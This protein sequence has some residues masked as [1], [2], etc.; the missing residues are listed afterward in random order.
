VDLGTNQLI[1]VVPVT[2]GFPLAVALSSDETKVIVGTDLGYEVLNLT[3]HAS[4]ATVSVGS[5]NAFSRHPSDP[6]LYATVNGTGVLEINR[7]TGVVARSFPIA[8]AVQGTAVAL[9]GSRLYV[10]EEF[11]DRI[12]VRNLLTGASEPTITTVGGFGMAL[13]PGGHF[14]YLTGGGHVHIVDRLSGALIR[15]VN[16]GGSPRR[17]AFSPDGIAVVTNEAGWVDF[18]R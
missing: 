8:G 7:E 16:V 13:A 1:D 12:H 6:L 2:H 5:I 4:V 17:I 9:D 11:T 10:A 15:S 3:T 14:L 18:I